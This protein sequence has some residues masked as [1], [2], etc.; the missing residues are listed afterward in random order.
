MS[1]KT[2]QTELKPVPAHKIVKLYHVY[3]LYIILTKGI[4]LKTFPL[5]K[6]FDGS[7]IYA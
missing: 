6:D 5:Y 2:V 7:N 1:Q 3:T 4:S